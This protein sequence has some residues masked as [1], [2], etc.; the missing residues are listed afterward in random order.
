MI[1]FAIQTTTTTTKKCHYSSSHSY[2]ILYYFEIVLF[3]LWT[4]NI[5]DFFSIWNS[6]MQMDNTTMGSITLLDTNQAKI[7]NCEDAYM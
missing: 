5:I 7:S 2:P 1:T 6:I 4:S 3:T